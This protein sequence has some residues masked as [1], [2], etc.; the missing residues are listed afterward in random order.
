GEDI[1]CAGLQGLGDI[2]G[3]AYRALQQPTV[4]REY[5]GEAAGG[6]PNHQAADDQRGENREQR[7]GERLQEPLPDGGWVGSSSTHKRRQKAE[8][9]KLGAAYCFLPSAFE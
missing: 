9:R 6:Y 3:R 4:G 7:H 5:L 2:A 1:R 8:G